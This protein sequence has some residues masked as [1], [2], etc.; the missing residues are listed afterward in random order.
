MSQQDLANVPVTDAQTVTP[1]G[2]NDYVSVKQT[3]GTFF[4]GTITS[5]ANENG[6]DRYV[7]TNKALNKTIDVA[8]NDKS[9]KPMFYFNRNKTKVQLRFDE[10]EVASLIRKL[11]EVEKSTGRKSEFANLTLRDFTSQKTKTQLLQGKRTNIMK[12]IVWEKEREINGKMSTKQ[13]QKEGRFQLYYDSNNG[14]RLAVKFEPK[15][16]ELNIPDEINQVKLNKQQKETLQAGG[17]IGL[18]KGMSYTDKQTGEIKEFDAY[19]AVDKDLNSVVVRNSKAINLEKVYGTKVP[20]FKKKLLE[21]GK[22]IILDVK[23]SGKEKALYI[24]VNAASTSPDGMI[25][26]D[27]EKAIEKGL[28]QEQEEKNEKKNDKSK[29]LNA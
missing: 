24:E 26:M 1:L 22:P 12:G 8:I 7:V 10:R 21:L 19:V 3:D 14:H 18:V 27:K 28:Y 5:I 16:L 20:M 11:K 29:G 15:V 17:N 2:V 23:L 4:K 13:M 9:I 6:L 25:K